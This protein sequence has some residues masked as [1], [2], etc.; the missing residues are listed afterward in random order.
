M[1]AQEIVGN[2]VAQKSE[3][4][5]TKITERTVLHNKADF[6]SVRVSAGDNI[7]EISA[8]KIGALK[9]FW[10]EL[11]RPPCW[12]IVIDRRFGAGRTDSVF[13]VPV[14]FFTARNMK[15]VDSFNVSLSAARVGG[16]RE[17]IGLVMKLF[18]AQTLEEIGEF[19]VSTGDRWLGMTDVGKHFAEALNQAAADQIAMREKAIVKWVDERFDARRAEQKAQAEHAERAVRE[20]AARK[21]YAEQQEAMGERDDD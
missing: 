2:V 20:E 10:K 11:V 1:V 7:Y 12:S 14:R 18:E 5:G 9:A 15:K 6:V 16:K 17:A 13:T 3:Q 19:A 21:K 8:S 4:N